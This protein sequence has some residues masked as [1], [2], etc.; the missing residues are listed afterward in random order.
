M[1]IPIDVLV[2]GAGIAG[3]AT[4][5]HLA[6]RRGVPGVVL[7]DE[8]PPMSLTSDKSTEC[9]RN[10]WPGPD[11]GMV[12][13]MKRS[14]DLMEELAGEC[15]NL[16]HL[17]RR[18]Y[19]YT[20]SD[21][22]GAALLEDF[23]RE[24]S[25]LGCGPL[26]I[27]NGRLDREVYIPP[28]VEGFEDQPS[29]ADLIVDRKLIDQ[30]FP[31]LSSDIH[32]V[33]HV[34][35]AGWMSAQQYGMYMLGQS[36]ERGVRLINGRVSSIEVEDGRVKSVLLA[37]GTRI[38][39]KVFV[40]AAGPLA[41]DVCAMLDVELP[42]HNELHYK[43]SFDDHLHA[44]ARSAPL[45]IFSD[46]GTLEWS[47]EE[48]AMLEDD[49]DTQWLT[50]LMPSGAHSR[51]EGG[52]HAQTLLMLWDLH[53]EPVEPILPPPVEPMYAELALRGLCGMVPALGKYLEKIPKPFIDGGYYTKTPE[54]R[55]L[56]CPLPVRG[57]YLVAGLSGFGIM[58]SAGLGELVAVYITGGELPDY[59]PSFHLNRYQDPEYQVLMQNWQDTWQL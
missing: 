39:T 23:A 56:A 35:R 15:N 27:H 58:A 51:P 25:S 28:A 33:L 7:V 18:G 16:F 4:A 14:I 54:N 59:A 57:A 41:A 11:E 34:R 40:N 2:C 48:R 44:V 43:A 9:Y 55:P 5:Y 38:Q 21:S 52:T 50:K 45:L 13:L 12:R 17:N 42:V 49:M 8:R 46:E 3:I 37:E 24:A 6:V 20:T 31:Y 32:A 10:W 36:K 29:G 47:D 1:S 26:R 19:L 30:H 53:E 22:H